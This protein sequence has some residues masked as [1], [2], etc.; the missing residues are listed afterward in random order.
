MGL[1]GS[2]AK[3]LSRAEACSAE[4]SGTRAARA[5]QKV[6]RP[7]LNPWA[8]RYTNP[9]ASRRVTD[10]FSGRRRLYQ[11]WSVAN[12]RV[13]LN[14]ANRVTPSSALAGTCRLKSAREWSASANRPAI[15]PRKKASRLLLPLLNSFSTRRTCLRVFQRP[16]PNRV[17]PPNTKIPPAVPQS[18]SRFR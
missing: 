13:L 9:A 10:S 8:P 3:A 15:A 4:K 1:W 18:A 7:A 6:S 11:Y 17:I 16:A 12:R 5:S 14:S 2:A